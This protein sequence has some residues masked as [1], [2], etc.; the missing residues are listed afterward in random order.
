MW[1]LDQVTSVQETPTPTQPRPPVTVLRAV[2]G[3]VA[4]GLTVGVG[5]LVAAVF[6]RAAAPLFAVG[7]AVIDLTPKPVRES[8]ISTFGTGDKTALLVGMGVIVALLAVLAGVLETS[9]RRW[10]SAL[11]AAFGALGVAAAVTR[12]AAGVWWFLPTVLGVA[13]GITFLRVM[14][15]RLDSPATGETD[16]GDA[17][18]GPDRRAFLLGASGGGAAA[19]V[20][21]VAGSALDHFFND[22]SRDRSAFSVPRAVNTI[23]QSAD[24]DGGATPFVTDNSDFYRIDTALQPPQLTSGAWSLRIH[25]MV[26]RE[27]RID[28]ASLRRMPAIEK[29]VTLTC[30]SNEV[31]GD[32][33]GNATWTGYRLR[34]LL[35]MAGPSDDADMVLSTSSDG[36]TAGTP[37]EAL[38]DD[39]DSLLAVAMNGTPLPIEH[40]Y[41]ARMVVPGLYGYVSATK[42]VVSL[43]VT[44]FDRAKAYWSTRGWSEKGPIKTSS[45]IDVPRDSATVNAGR[46]AVG[47]V[48]WAQPRGINAVQVQVD[49]GPWQS[50]R[51]L[52]PDNIDT[53]RLWS[54]DWDATSGD[55]TL[56]VRAIDGEGRQQ[57]AVVSRPDPDGSTGLHTIDVS[58]S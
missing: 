39:R 23:D 16:S 52:A 35:A 49:D 32:L 36:F 34:D 14:A 29:M 57:S 24:D 40:G 47:G 2:N 20:T 21:G 43:E 9:R 30:V 5:Q 7:S 1:I 11:F 8:A 22:V 44:R 13:A 18:Q 25:G 48:A 17:E 58:V 51:L 28:M 50:A 27:V 37:I 33:I 6:D 19:V 26:D 41:P 54:W 4:A 56:T 45:R 31:G 42:W 55:H 3:I 12:P 46:V 53:W 38:T 10:G 15:V